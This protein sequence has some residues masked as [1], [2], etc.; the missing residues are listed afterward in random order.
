VGIT[1]LALLSCMGQRPEA[2]TPSRAAVVRRGA[3]YLA[4]QQDAQGRLGPDCPALLYNHAMATL[5]LLR[6]GAR[7]RDDRWRNAV[8][9][10]VEFIGAEQKESGGWGY[11]HAAD[12]SANSSITV[13]PLRALLAADAAGVPGLKPRIERGLAWLESNVN[14]QGLMGY[15]RAG[16]FPNG[17]ETL[18]AAG[19]GCLLNAAA[20]GRT[21]GR[22]AGM[23]RAIRESAADPGKASDYY[24]CYFLAAAVDAAGGPGSAP[25]ITR[26]RESLVGRQTQSGPS[27][28]SWEPN[29]PWSPAGGRTY[30]TAMALMTLEIR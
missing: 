16:D 9:K 2:L 20:K 18:T 30:S 6:A 7:E 23:M 12:H 10:A 25:L 4:R 22:L 13:W 3:D 11:R 27:A 29:D 21:P 14:R 26:L 28:G 15:T 24:R 19:A 5:A 8:E 1:A 17:P